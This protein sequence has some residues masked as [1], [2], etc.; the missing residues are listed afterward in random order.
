MHNALR[1][2][3]ANCLINADYYGEGG[4]VIKN[5]KDK[6]TIE[7]PGILRI[8]IEEAISGGFSSPRNSMLMKMFNILDI[9][10]RAGSGI[11][12]IYNVW[13]TQKWERPQISERLGNIDRIC[14]ILP[15]EKV[16]I[17]SADK[18]DAIA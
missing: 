6:I 17:K 1:E 18:K 11:P 15:I 8:R 5:D 13:K 12:N 7:N 2:A 10:E 4:I 9:G 14:L 3:L 16:P